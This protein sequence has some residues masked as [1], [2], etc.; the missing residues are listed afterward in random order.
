MG[1]TYDYAVPTNMPNGLYWYHSHRH[2]VT[3]Q[4]TYMGLAGLLE[5]GRPDG[6]LPLVTKNN[7][8][9]RDMA[10]QYNFVF[11]RKNGGHQL[12]NPYW[13]Q[14][15]STLKPPEG[16]QLADGTYRPS[17]APV[18]FSET[19]K[20][21]EFFTNWYAGPLSIHNHR[22]QNQFVPQNLQSFTSPTK[23]IPA[24][25]SLPENERDVQFT[26]NGQFQ[27][28]LKLK[29]GQTE[30]WVLANISD[31]AFVPLRFTETATGNHPKFADRRAGRQPLHPGAAARRRRRNVPRHPAGVALRDRGDDAARRAISCSTCRRARAS[32]GIDEPGVLYT[33][34]GTENS[35][36]VLG[37]VTV[38]PK[39]ISYADGFFTFPTQTLLQVTPDSGEGQTTAFEPGQN[40]DAY[41]SFVDTSVMKPDVTR[42]LEIGGGFGNEKASNNDPKAF[43]YQ[44]DDNIFPNIPLIQPRLNSV[45]EWKFTNFNNDSHPMHI[46]VNDFQV[47]QVVES[48]HRHHHRRAA[49][50]HRQRE[51]PAAGDRRERQRARARIADVAHR[52]HRVHG[53]V[54][55]PLPPPQPRGQRADGD[56]QRHPR[57]V[58]VRGRGARVARASRRRCRSTTATATR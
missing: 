35:P 37:T 48:A 46:H 43:T 28:E 17:L 42:E 30:I 3:A 53:H 23:T 1:N 51:C 13:E 24:D 49:V 20:G 12:N 32:S 31:F 41:T 15:V 56:H 10:L 21:A 45:E 40:L 57:G 58:D 34:N 54:R 7:I 50:G 19:T 14:W 47:Q 16:N 18:N 27:P 22:G 33:N 5:I 25:P 55:G 2:T 4:Q 26:V 8:P 29:P 6:N 44:F 9:I 38:D 52:V 36:A 11:D 39:Y